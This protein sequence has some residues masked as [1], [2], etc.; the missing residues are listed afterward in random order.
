MSP[1]SDYT[2]HLFPYLPS[3]S[4]RTL[5]CGHVIPSSNLLAWNVS[6]GPTGQ[7]LTFTFANRSN[8]LMLD[9]LGR[10]LLNICTIVPDGV[11][12]FFPSYSYLSS[13]IS[14]WSHP[15]S[16]P[17]EKNI[18]QRLGDKKPIFTEKKDVSVETVL[19]E[20]ARAI[21]TG[22]G[23]LLLSVV[24][25]KMSEGINFSD[26]LGRCVV[27]VGLPFPNIASAEWKAKIQ[28]IESST[29]ERL[30]QSS[31]SSEPKMA[32]S[33]MEKKRKR[34]RQ[35]ILRKCLYESS[36]PEYRQSD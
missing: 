6:H 10:T 36:E 15:P 32:K 3:T 8:T 11:V 26:K 34:R 30:S 27:I 25:G 31:T 2:S 12:V 29:I 13:I 19:G 28:Y 16:K 20:Y 17:S 21:D 23:G 7:P 5:S 24:G 22:K 1:F 18:F 9:E 14:H 4:I 33:E 35:G